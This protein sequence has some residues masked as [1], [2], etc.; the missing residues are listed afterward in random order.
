MLSDRELKSALISKALA[1]GA[2]AAGV[3]AADPA[4]EEGG[5]AAFADW[6]ARG[7]NDGMDWL[8]RS[9]DR[10]ADLRAWFPEARSVLMLAFPWGA[11]EAPAP[12]GPPSGRFARYATLPDYHDELRGRLDSLRAWYAEEAAPGGKARPF[13]DTSPVLERLYA[14]RSGLGWV[15]KNAMLISER[16]GC[17]F[18]LA[19]L[20]LDRELEPDAP[21]AERCGECRRC[22]DACPTSAFAAPRVLDAAR[23]VACWT[24]ERRSVPFPEEVERGLGARVFGCDECVEACPF[25]R[26]APAGALSPR[27][28]AALPLD[29]LLRLDEAAFAA[30]FTG[31]PV[32]RAGLPALLR[33]A[34]AAAG[35]S[36]ARE[37]LPTVEA[38]AAHADPLVAGQARRSAARLAGN[39]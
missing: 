35:N 26:A 10:R 22:L 34:L 14:R 28:A 19:G 31:T 5:G 27:L 8:A 11:P 30:R 33:N 13:V 2:G 29:E 38:L 36:G 6:L 1:L 20:A 25:N 4:S 21:S 9:P 7:F 3:C 37:L 32:L 23:C 16:L 18:F 24:V 12:G 15:G 39:P 17:R